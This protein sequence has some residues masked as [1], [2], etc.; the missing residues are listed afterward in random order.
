M[1]PINVGHTRS[2]GANDGIGIRVFCWSF[3]QVEIDKYLPYIGNEM[4]V[5]FNTKWYQSV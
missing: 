3:I 5:I 1:V 2:D 4:L